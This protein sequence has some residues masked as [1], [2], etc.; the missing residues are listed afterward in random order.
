MFCEC[1]DIVVRYG[2]TV[3]LDVRR[4]TIPAG[5][6]TTVV[7]PNGAGKTTL[8]EVLALLRRPTRGQVS[9]WGRPAEPS[10]REIQK[11]I[12]MVMHPGYMFRGAVWHNVMYGLRARGTRRSEARLR[13]A[14]A[15]KMVGMSDFAH[16]NVADLS[17][18]ERQRVNLARAIAIGPQAVLLD[19]PSANVDTRTVAL[20]RKLLSRLSKEQGTTVIHTSPGN[21]QLHDIAD[22]VVYMEAGRILKNDERPSDN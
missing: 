15:L 7:G 11:K 6:I 20:I 12:V 21:S 4:L 8:L 16:R 22:G 18:G 1:H 10:D 19:E 2:R 14:D 17:A 13:A 9:L 3:V 5:R